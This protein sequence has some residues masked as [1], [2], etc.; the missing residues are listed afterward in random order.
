MASQMPTLVSTIGTE[1][2]EPYIQSTKQLNI[3]LE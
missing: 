2:F 1:S 3:S